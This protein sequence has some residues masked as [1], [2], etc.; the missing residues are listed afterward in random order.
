[1]IKV[2]V[3]QFFKISKNLL[4]PNDDFE[5]SNEKDSC[6]CTLTFDE[7]ADLYGFTDADDEDIQ[8]MLKKLRRKRYE[9]KTR[10]CHK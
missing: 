10:F 4:Q 3:D 1:M 2:T 9:T 6:I 5:S 8:K 7:A